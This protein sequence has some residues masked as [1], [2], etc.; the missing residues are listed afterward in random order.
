MKNLK[1]GTN[2]LNLKLLTDQCATFGCSVVKG[3]GLKP[4]TAGIPK[5]PRKIYNS[6]MDE[7]YENYY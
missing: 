1:K 4:P 5:R 6:I 7:I 3:A 2:P